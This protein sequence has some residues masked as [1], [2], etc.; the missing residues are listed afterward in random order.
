MQLE[1]RFQVAKSRDA[2]VETLGQEEVLVSLFPGETEIVDRDGDK[3]TTRTR[4]TALG[5][6]GHA[7]FNWHFRMD[8]SIAF[9]KVC[10]GRVWK[11][12]RGTVEVEEAAAGATILIE[13]RGSTKAFVPEFTIKGP[14]EDQLGDMADALERAMSA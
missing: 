4:Y 3:I 1:R 12:L 8:G 5:Q 11:E 13:M 6:E 10:D 14:M 2:V 7:T 9:D